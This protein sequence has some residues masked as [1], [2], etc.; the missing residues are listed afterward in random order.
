MRDNPL[1][2]ELPEWFDFNFYESCKDFSENEWCTALST[3]AV[4]RVRKDLVIED[5]WGNP[6]ASAEQ[7]Y[8]VFSG[9][10]TRDLPPGPFN[11]PVSERQK[12]LYRSVA[13]LVVSHLR[14]TWQECLEQP[15]VQKYKKEIF[16]GCYGG[17]PPEKVQEYLDVARTPV[18]FLIPRYD[19]GDFPEI[20]N[21]AHFVADLDAPDHVLIDQFKESLAEMRAQLKARAPMKRFTKKDFRSWAEKKVLMYIDLKLLADYLGKR[22]THQAMGLALFPDEYAVALNEKVRNTIKPLADELLSKSTISSF[23]RQVDPSPYVDW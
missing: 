2:F 12:L 23:I 13:P 6:D 15:E 11:S 16:S 22:V 19:E 3:R 14:L 9:I 18:D 10:Y 20:H 8:R 21:F 1:P 5:G 7:M 17:L 4:L